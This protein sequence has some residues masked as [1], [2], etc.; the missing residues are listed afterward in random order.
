[1]N[2]KQRMNGRW[3]PGLARLSPNYSNLLQINDGKINKITPA[4]FRVPGQKTFFEKIL[5]WLPLATHSHAFKMQVQYQPLMQYPPVVLVQAPLT[6]Q[7]PPTVRISGRRVNLGC[8]FSWKALARLARCWSHPAML[9]IGFVWSTWSSQYYSLP[10]MQPKATVVWLK[11]ASKGTCC[12]Y[13]FFLS[14]LSV[15][16]LQLGCIGASAS[17]SWCV[18]YSVEL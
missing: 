5:R 3:K 6:T 14:V 15:L 1:M 16:I 10:S 2:R 11:N 12:T 18:G 17:Y 13:V 4:T 8:Y 7:N 9:Y